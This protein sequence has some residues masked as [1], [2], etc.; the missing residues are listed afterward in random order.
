MA[1]QLTPEFYDKEQEHLAAFDARSQARKTAPPNT[2]S[3]RQDELSAPLRR[4]SLQPEAPRRS[5]SGSRALPPP[6]IEVI[7]EEPTR[8]FTEI[9]AYCWAL[10]VASRM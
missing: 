6:Q 10:E 7:R 4:M 3:S 2:S 5:A 1:N 9:D 8:R